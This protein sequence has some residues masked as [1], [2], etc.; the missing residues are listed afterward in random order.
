MALWD[1]SQNIRELVE[2]YDNSSY[3]VKLENKTV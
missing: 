3:I 1:I 2:L